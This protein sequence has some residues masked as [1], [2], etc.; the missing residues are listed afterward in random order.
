M[1]KLAEK[2]IYETM[3]E[4]GTEDFARDFAKSVKD[5]DIICFFGGVGSGKTVFTRGLCHGLGFDGYVNSPSYIIMNM[6]ENGGMNIYHFDLYRIGSSSELTEI[7]FYD[8]IYR[9][10]SVSI[11]EWADM[12]KDCLPER[13]IDVFI[14]VTGENSRKFDI[15]RHG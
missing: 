3:S 1:D 15:T 10:N 4:E 8:F 7:G 5:G 11:V 14:S 2:I 9:K 13:R 12:I 6:Y